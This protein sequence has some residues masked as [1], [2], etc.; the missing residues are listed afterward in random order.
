MTEYMTQAVDL[1]HQY[2]PP[3]PAMIQDSKVNNKVAV[4]PVEPGRIIRVT[5]NDFMKPGDL[6][7]A[8]LNIQQKVILEINVST[9]LEDQQDGI[10]VNVAFKQLPD[11]TSYSGQTTLDA[12]SKDI[13]VVVENTG[14]RAL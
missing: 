3:N 14:H 2:V 1:V 5:F 11:G 12:K 6:M 13:K 7:S 10:V 4:E 9:W 8:I